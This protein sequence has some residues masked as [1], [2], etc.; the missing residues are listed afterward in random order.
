MAAMA[1]GLVLLPAC[2]R[3]PHHADWVI[4]SAV[5]VIGPAPPGGYRLIFPYIVGD[6]YGSANT[7]DFVVPVSGGAGGF[8]L[9]LNRTQRA[10]EAELAP[11]A[12]SLGFLKITPADARIARLAPLAL[13]RNGIDPVGTVQWRGARDGTALM[14]LYVDRPALITGAFSR[15]GQTIRYEIRAVKPGYVWIA[16]LRR[17]AGETLYTVVPRPRHLTLTITTRPRAPLR[18]PRL[19][20]SSE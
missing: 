17:G 1:A 6:L 8:T 12:F 15:A 3:V 18:K 11:T 2:A 14:L 9:D 19:P 5:E 10:L 20:Q 4:H 16:G 13:Q 7:G